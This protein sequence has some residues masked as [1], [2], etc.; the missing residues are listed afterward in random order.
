MYNVNETRPKFRHK[1]CMCVLLEARKW[2]LYCFYLG[3][4][5][6]RVMGN[7]LGL[8]SPKWAL[9]T[10]PR[11]SENLGLALKNKIHCHRIKP[12]L[13]SFMIGNWLEKAERA[14]QWQEMLA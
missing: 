1:V 11:R 5:L 2:G 12:K 6:V 9:S 14:Y 7:C 8:A 10:S 3:K 13:G 4:A